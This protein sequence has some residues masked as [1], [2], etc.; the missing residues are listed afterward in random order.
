LRGGRHAAIRPPRSR[1]V[2]AMQ[3]NRTAA[4]LRWIGALAL[5]VTAGVAL[6]IGLG[7]KPAASRAA[8]T[9]LALVIGSATVG[10]PKLPERMTGRPVPK[11]V[12]LPEARRPARR[13][14]ASTPSATVTPSLAQTT[15]AP[16]PASSSP[17]PVATAENQTPRAD[18]RAGVVGG[19]PR[20]ARRPADRS[21][22]R[23]AGLLDA[24]RGQ[25]PA[26]GHH[27]RQQPDQR[28][29]ARLRWVGEDRRPSGGR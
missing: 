2:A 24:E 7:G 4:R 22:H 9:P 13:T 12:L 25:L 8:K 3:R 11:Q 21:Q 6:T 23:L 29:P 10:D 5:S 15:P 16:S 19:D 18:Q 20:R 28:Q 17:A 14:L 26:E 27:W 1:S